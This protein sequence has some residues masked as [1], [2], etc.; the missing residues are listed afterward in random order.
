MTELRIFSFKTLMACYIS[1]AVLRRSL[2]A[3]AGLLILLPSPVHTPNREGCSHGSTR[4]GCSQCHSLSIT[5]HLH[6]HVQTL[7]RLRACGLFY[8]AQVAVAGSEQGNRANRKLAA[9]AA[10]QPLQSEQTRGIISDL[11][12]SQETIF[13]P[14]IYRQAGF[15][16]G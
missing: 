15:K 3:Q 6:V 9:H 10:T 16:K 2:V 14:S 13:T 5:R 11:E 4:Y 1:F 7:E 8:S 12:G